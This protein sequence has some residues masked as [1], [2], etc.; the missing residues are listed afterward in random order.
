MSTANNTNFRI[1]IWLAVILMELLAVPFTLGYTNLLDV[2]AI[3]NLYAAMGYPPLTGWTAYGGDPCIDVWQ[4]V[5][6]VDSTI[7]TIVLNGANLGGQLS[8]TLVDFTSIVTIDL[9]NNHISGTL[10]EK[11]PLTIQNFYLSDNQF[12]G[13]IPNNL[14]ELKLLSDISLSHNRLTGEL[15]DVF[16]TLTGLV[17]MDLSFNNLSGPLPFSMESLSSLTTLHVQNNQLSGTLDVLENLPLKDLNVANNLFSGSIPEKLLTVAN[18]TNNGNSF[19]TSISPSPVPPLPSSPSNSQAP[20]NL[21][22][23][24]FGGPSIQDD[25]PLVKTKKFSVIKVIAYA[26]VAISLLIVAMLTVM[27]CI[28]K[29]K[30]RKSSDGEIL[31][32]QVVG[33]H[34]SPKKPQINTGLAKSNKVGKFSL[35]A[36]GGQRKHNIDITGSITL[37]RPSLFDKNIVN[38]MIPTEIIGRNPMEKQVPSISAIPFSVASLQQYTSSFSEKNLIREGSIG[39]VYLAAHPERELLTVLKLNNV[40]SKIPVDDFLELIRSIS[41]LRHPNIVGLVGYC[42]DFGQRLLVYNLFSKRTLNDV[43]HF[44]DDLKKK[45]SWNARIRIA[46]ESAKALEYLHECCG[47]HVVHQKFEPNNILINDELAVCVSE[48][49]LA[50]MLSSCFGTQLSGCS[51]V[52][53]SYEAPEVSESAVWSELSDV[54]SFG[55]VLLELLTG[56]IP[57]DSSRP[58]AEKHLVRWASSQLHDISTLKRMVDPSMNGRYSI[59]SLSRFADIISRCIQRGPEFRP[60]MSEVVQ[61]LSRALDDALENVDIQLG[62]KANN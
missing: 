55:I 40:N 31:R 26:I 36:I 35:E 22:A 1:S 60:P 17:N 45:L 34:G 37:E 39:Q 3:N 9:S 28:S 51:H 8:D 20:E 11:L 10:P 41:E 13:I 33:T 47:K 56:R 52:L 5:Q 29:W 59:R 42:M 44:E 50:S 16:H 62:K 53:C 25:S 14:S 7:S 58:Q 24:T 18:F 21:P 27:F 2:Y 15:P 46:L 12:T 4:G 38:C 32:K 23:S 61:D 54:Y 43:L 48:C 49:G 19:N 30:E 57:Y 6:C